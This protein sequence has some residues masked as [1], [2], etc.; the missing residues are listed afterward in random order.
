IINIPIGLLGIFYSIKH[1]PNF[2]MP[3]RKFDLHG[4]IF[5]GFGLVMLSFSLDLFGY[6]NISRYITL[7]E[8]LGGFYLLGIYI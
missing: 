8:I 1:M 2:T 7:A 3:K 4:F 5:F 6:K